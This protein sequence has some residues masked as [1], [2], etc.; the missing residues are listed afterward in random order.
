ML[1]TSRGFIKA[2]L[3]NLVTL[4]FYN[5][6]LIHCFAKETN[7]A[8]AEDGRHTK[9]LLAYVLL[10]MI[11]FGIYGIFWYCNWIG[12]CNSMLLRHQRPQGL[13]MSTYLLTTLLLGVLTFGIMFFVVYA[14]IL[15]LQNG[16][17][18]LYNDLNGFKEEP[19][20]ETIEQEEVREIAM[21]F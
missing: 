13:Q 7:I 10:N 16:V 1:P 11:T 21:E 2:F 14:K 9:G 6:Y 17:N 3:L 20:E 5:W 4:G 15:Y 8:C 18:G 12:R 19:A